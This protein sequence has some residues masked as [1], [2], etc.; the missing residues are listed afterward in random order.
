VTIQQDCTSKEQNT[1]VSLL[2]TV[3]EITSNQD[4]PSKWCDCVTC[5]V[6]VTLNV[7]K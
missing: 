5:R 7:V 6:N 3:V 1:N 4:S 2:P